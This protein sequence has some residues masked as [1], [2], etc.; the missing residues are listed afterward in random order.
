MSAIIKRFLLFMGLLLFLF[1]ACDKEIPVMEEG[2]C[3]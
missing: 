3:T 2:Y 1:P